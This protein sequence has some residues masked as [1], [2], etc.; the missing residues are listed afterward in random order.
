MSTPDSRYYYM[1]SLSK[2]K[3]ERKLLRMQTKLKEDEFR[4]QWDTLKEF[5]S[6]GNVR[7]L[8][9]EKLT[10]MKNI[11]GIASGAFS[12]IISLIAG[13][14]RRRGCGCDF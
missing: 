7:M 8:I 2:L 13:R 11:F 3:S 4:V 12:T 5:V 9:D 14:H 6:W 10:P 1:D